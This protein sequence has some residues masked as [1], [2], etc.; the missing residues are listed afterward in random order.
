MN[1]GVIRLAV[2]G[3]FSNLQDYQLDCVRTLFAQTESIG[4][5]VDTFDEGTMAGELF[6]VAATV[7]C[8]TNEEIILNDHF[9]LLGVADIECPRRLYE[10]E[11][12]ILLREEV[13]EKMV[14]DPDELSAQELE[15]A[16]SFFAG[17][18]GCEEGS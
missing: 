16:Q 1:F 7:G 2:T 11:F 10:E 14:R 12:P 8:L 4:Q 9:N 3:A 17:L 6:M 15:F 5:S 18:E 13:G